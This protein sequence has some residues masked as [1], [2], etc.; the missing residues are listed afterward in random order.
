MLVNEASLNETSL[1]LTRRC[2]ISRDLTEELLE[3][4]T[5]MMFNSVSDSGIPTEQ[6]K[7]LLTKE[8]FRFA[9]S[10]NL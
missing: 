10:R 8:P 9:F 3:A 7:D 1:I 5:E 2:R 4:M 6:Y